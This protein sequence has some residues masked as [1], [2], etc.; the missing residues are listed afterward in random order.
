MSVSGIAMT[1][2]G[3]LAVYGFWRTRSKISRASR[4]R[5]KKSHYQTQELASR[6]CYGLVGKPDPS[7]IG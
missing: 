4:G 5:A 1:M 3:S 2:L 7:V 6:G